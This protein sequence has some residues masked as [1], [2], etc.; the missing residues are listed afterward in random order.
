MAVGPG[1]GKDIPELLRNGDWNFG[2]FAF[3]TGAPFDENLVACFNC[4][5]SMMPTD[6][7]YSSRQLVN[8]ASADATQYL[9][10]NLR[11]RVPCE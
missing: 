11:R 7:L 5:Q 4:H 8:Y 9:F 2:S 6:F 10:C 3:A 1:W